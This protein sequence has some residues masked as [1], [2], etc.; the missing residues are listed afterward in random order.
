VVV[1]QRIESPRL[2][3]NPMETRGV[4]AQYERGNGVLTVWTST[5]GA[6]GVRDALVTLFGLPE[7]RVRVVAPE[8]GGGFGCKFGLY[9]E[10]ALAA[11]CARHLGQ[12]IKWIERRSEHHLATN[13][14]RGQVAYISLAARRDGTFTGLRLK[15][16]A[17][18]GTYGLTFLA[19]LT[20]TMI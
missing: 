7:S 2:V 4:V 19:G 15:L 20:A 18:L 9:V 16:I 13:H 10:D 1:T 11:W 6:H 12:P 14:G 3:P 8:V 17:D 5:Q